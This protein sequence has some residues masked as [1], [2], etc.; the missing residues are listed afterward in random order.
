M[1]HPAWLEFASDRIYLFD[2]KT[3]ETLAQAEFALMG[4]KKLTI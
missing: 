2:S 1:G 4:E 3:E